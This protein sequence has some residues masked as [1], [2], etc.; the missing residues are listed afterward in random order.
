MEKG[1]EQGQERGEDDITE[2]RE[3]MR[4]IGGLR[5][6]ERAAVHGRGAHLTIQEVSWDEESGRTKSSEGTKAKECE[7][8]ERV[9]RVYT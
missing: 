3:N 5:R 4:R 2:P 7:Y 9:Q 8:G 1:D 6:R